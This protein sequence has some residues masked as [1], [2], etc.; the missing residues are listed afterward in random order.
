MISVLSILRLR[1][2][3]GKIGKS[4]SIGTPLVMRIPLLLILLL[5]ASCAAGPPT[6]TGSS[7][8]TDQASS[9]SAQLEQAGSAAERE[10][11]AAY[12]KLKKEAASHG[13][14][15][16]TSDCRVTLYDHRS[17]L[18]IGFMNESSVKASA[19]Y[20]E[21]RDAASFKGVEDLNMGAFLKQLE[22]SQFFSTAKNGAVRTPGASTSIVLTRNDRTWTL[23]STHDSSA[24]VMQV[25]Q[26]CAAAVRGIYDSSMSFQLIKN[27]QGAE[28]FKREG[29]RVRKAFQER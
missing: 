14:Y 7:S 4:R 21:E 18:R 27:E 8:S 29:E 2:G 3:K 6:S 12:E 10:S 9:R 19:Y 20:S 11:V 1:P 23:T 26:D 28:L 15:E 16:E 22:E 25:V 24:E 17:G 13:I 5:V